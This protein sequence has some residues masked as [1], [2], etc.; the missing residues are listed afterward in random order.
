MSF[1]RRHLT[2]AATRLDHMLAASPSMLVAYLPAGYPTFAD[3]ITAFHAL[4]EHAP[5]LEIGLPEPFSERRTVRIAGD[6][7]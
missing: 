2:S 1:P 7:R 3:S 5:V 4:A 6:L